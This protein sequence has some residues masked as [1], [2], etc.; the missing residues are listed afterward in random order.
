MN[1]SVAFD[2]LLPIWLIATL[3]ILTL[4]A[5]MFAEW[6]GLKSF[7]LRA[8]AAFIMCG[9]LLNPQKLLEAR[10]PLPDVT[11]ILTD[12]SESMQ[13]SDRA[14]VA[15][16]LETALKEK[17]GNL[18][19]IEIVQVDVNP[20]E[21]G[22][23]LTQAMIDGLGQLPVDRIAGIFALSDGQIHDVPNS[24]EGLLP[25][26]VPFH[27][28]IVGDDNARDRRLEALIAPKFGMV[29]EQ[30]NFELRIEDP[31]FEGERA[32]LEI[33][34]NGELVVGFNA[35][36]GDTI[37]IPLEIE[38]RGINTVEI[39]TDV[40][41]GE[42][43]PL[44]NV[45]VAEISGV[46]DRLRVLLI[47]GQP[48]IGGR[49]WRNLL[50]SDPSV[51][52]VQF[53]IL[54]NPGVKNANALPHELSLIQFPERELFEEKLNEF[55]LII[56]DQ[57][58]RRSVVGR[59][60]SRP[61]LNP[62]Y[63]ANVANYVEDGGA[64]LVATGP[65]FAGEESLARS[66]LIA[67]LPARPT[68]KLDLTAFRPNLSE[69]GTRHPITAIFDG[70]IADRWGKWYRS[71]DA[72]VIGGDVLMVDDNDKPLL[73]VDKV[74]RGRTAL[75]LSDQAWLWSKN[76]DGGGPY[77]E[78]FR[79]LSH[80]LMGEPDLEA[81][82]LTARVENGTLT[83]DYYSLDDENKSIE[84]LGPD[85]TPESLT[86]K[87]LSPGHFQATAPA[88]VQG[89]YRVSTEELTAIAAAGTLNPLEYKHIL[90]TS[91]ILQPLSTASGGGMFA[92]NATSALPAIR[93]V[94]PNANA[95]SENFAGVVRHNQFNVTE[96]RRTPF[97]PTW[98]YFLLILLA[99]LGAWRLEGR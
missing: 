89:A 44:N 71:V 86:L 58:Q 81:D 77:N 85:G 5:A 84:I 67:V 46:R 98:L 51:D 73:I 30:A 88:G 25:E 8:I 79:R 1:T 40:A 17:L 15:K 33:R 3:T 87:R 24:V 93:K 69:K 78:M 48:H 29:G 49:A 14:S 37:S 45:F 26:G 42:L 10:T 19:N 96:S 65:A 92:A 13:I 75:L 9:A 28:L 55:D 52:L 20:S 59:G 91:E 62:Y 83:I 56:F 32:R 16:Q 22:T 36:I 35:L 31:G 82:R 99:L 18:E 34:L 76:H 50:K 61:M 2:P 41:P 80:W 74:K 39:R 57:F 12:K 72:E 97:G 66:P 23:R 38:K 95:A 70:E 4:M 11:L 21:D 27:S 54:T 60:R 6:K 90:P 7:V 47:T 53:T 43:T 64:L 63:I 68:G 94:G